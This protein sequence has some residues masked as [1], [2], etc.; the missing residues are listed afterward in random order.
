MAWVQDASGN[1]YDDGSSSGTTTDYSNYV[2]P[3]NPQ[4]QAAPTYNPS[5]GVDYSS[6]FGL[7]PNMAGSTAPTNSGTGTFDPSQLTPQMIQQLLAS[8]NSAGNYGGAST[9]GYG[10]GTG[11]T[12]PLT[13]IMS[14]LPSWLTGSMNGATGNGGSGSSL[15]S[16][17]AGLAGG[18]GNLGALAG[19]L[20]GYLGSKDPLTG[21]LTSSGTSNGS[22]NQSQ[23]GNQNTST[24]NSNIPA[25]AMPYFQQNVQNAQN[26][27]GQGF[28]STQNQAFNS[29]NGL[30]QNDPYSAN[31]QKLAND[32]MSGQYLSPESNP[33]LA[34]TASAMGSQMADAYG[35]GTSAQTMA[36]FQKNGAY[37]GSAMQETQAAN[38]QAFGNSLGNAM[39][40][41]YGGNYSQERTNQLN[42]LNNTPALTNN[43]YTGANNQLAIGN[44]Q[45]NLGFQNQTM[46][47]NTLA[48]LNGIQTNGTQT[49]NTSAN[50]SGTNTGATTGQQN[51]S[52]SQNPW[53]ALL[54]GGVTGYGLGNLLGGS[55]TA[56]GTGG[57]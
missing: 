26:L 45:Q 36:Q 49:G 30:A 28:N 41:L 50:M 23:T 34:Q 37:G 42:T 51:T 8:A 47:G 39:N 35:R 15:L 13:G 38:N 40:Q 43:L 29:I 56:Y 54:G 18:S 12:N 32:T 25:W 1:W 46:M 7:D 20:A 24:S 52:Q 55:K 48:G 31:T 11:S 3:F 14:S 57:Q 33:Y 19:G 10:Q 4:Y 44:Q 16:S 5:Q 53:A 6:M 27:A 9:G 2:D 22:Q 17:L 21:S